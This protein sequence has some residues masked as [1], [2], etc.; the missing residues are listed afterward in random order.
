MTHA[1][2]GYYMVSEIIVA[3]GNRRQNSENVGEDVWSIDER[4]SDMTRDLDLV[5]LFE[6]PEWQKHC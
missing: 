2:A 3:I 6:H 1:E 4:A 5:V